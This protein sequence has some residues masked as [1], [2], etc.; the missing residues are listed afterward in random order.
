MNHV[1]WGDFILVCN[2][3]VKYNFTEKRICLKTLFT[4]KADKKMYM[5]FNAVSI[6][7]CVLSIQ[8]FFVLVN[9]YEDQIQK[10]TQDMDQQVQLVSDLDSEVKRLQVSHTDWKINAQ[11]F[12]TLKF[13]LIFSPLNTV[14]GWQ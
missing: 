8:I 3:K 4:L 7:V 14:S 10:K 13:L 9:D 11:K 12:P 2:T 1:S 5:W 6:L